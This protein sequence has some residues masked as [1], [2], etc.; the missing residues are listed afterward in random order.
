MGGQLLLKTVF[1]YKTTGRRLYEQVHSLLHLLQ[2]S[3]WTGLIFRV[4]TLRWSTV[5]CLACGSAESTVSY[6]ARPRHHHQIHDISMTLTFTRLFTVH[7]VCCNAPHGLA[8]GDHKPNVNPTVQPILHYRPHQ[9][10]TNFKNPP[11]H[12]I[13]QMMRMM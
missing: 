12:Q 3:S 10:R 1:V 8:D 4:V 6:R 11:N 2:N 7:S 13:S 9:L 5:I